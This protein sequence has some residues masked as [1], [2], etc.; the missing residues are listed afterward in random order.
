MESFDYD[1]TELDITLPIGGIPTTVSCI[2]D[3]D[4]DTTWIREL[5]CVLVGDPDS[6]I[7]LTDRNGARLVRRH[8]DRVLA[9]AKIRLDQ[10]CE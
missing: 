8:L 6:E 4:G 9:A 2:A 5:Y 3:T 1:P 7:Q 10:Q